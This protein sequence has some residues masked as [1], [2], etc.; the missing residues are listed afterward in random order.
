MQEETVSYG[1]G[2]NLDVDKDAEVTFFVS[3]YFGYYVQLVGWI[4][5]TIII[6]L[7]FW[8]IIDREISTIHLLLYLIWTNQLFP[9][10]KQTNTSTD[11]NKN[12]KSARG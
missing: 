8:G 1:D 4:Y 12:E 7:E 6:A 10:L 5:F 9:L 11:T 2:I 3:T